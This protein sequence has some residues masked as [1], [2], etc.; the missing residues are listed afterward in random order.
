MNGKMPNQW[1]TFHIIPISKS[2]N[3]N[4]VDNYRGIA[5]SAISLKMTNKMILIR[6]QPIISSTLRNNQNGFRPGKSTMTHILSLRRLIEWVKSKNMNAIITYVDFRK[7]FDSIDRRMFKILILYGIPKSLVNMIS[8]TYKNT[9]A[10]VLTPVAKQ[11]NFTYTLA[12][13]KETH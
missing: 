1:S 9:E 11:I 7:A 8:I 3:L 12:Y 10:K 13:F 6:I 4:E 5:L 2:G